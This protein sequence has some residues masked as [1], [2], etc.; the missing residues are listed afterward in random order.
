[1]MYDQSRQFEVYIVASLYIC[2]TTINIF[3]VCS[4]RIAHCK[5]LIPVT[6][7]AEFT[8]TLG[9]LLQIHSKYYDCT[10]TL[11]CHT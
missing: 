3:I 8:V 6:C 2:M 7:C 9:I 5:K 10:E 4:T 11:A 1:M